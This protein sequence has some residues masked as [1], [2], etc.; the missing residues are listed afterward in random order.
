MREETLIN[1]VNDIDDIRYKLEDIHQNIMEQ[2][3]YWEKLKHQYAGMA[4]QGILS[5]D[6][7]SGVLGMQKMKELDAMI[8]DMSVKIAT[9]LINRL[10]EDSQCEK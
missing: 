1:A 9:T 8:G 4:M 7:I 3:D 5:G 10:K 2:P 6:K